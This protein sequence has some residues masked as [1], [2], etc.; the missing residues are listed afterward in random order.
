MNWDSQQ[1]HSRH[2]DGSTPLHLCKSLE[3][4]F[5][6]SFL[7]TISFS[8]SIKML[9]LLCKKQ[10]DVDACNNDGETPLIVFIKEKK[11]T[12]STSCFGKS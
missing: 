8:I 4:F 6:N 2:K 11:V 9:T 1:V 3:V 5:F 12:I 10:S 7:S